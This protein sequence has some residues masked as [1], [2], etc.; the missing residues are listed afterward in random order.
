MVGSGGASPRR[1]RRHSSQGKRRGS[2]RWLPPGD[3]NNDNSTDTPRTTPAGTRMVY[4]QY[5]GHA[6][7][8]RYCARC[9]RP[10]ADNPPRGDVDYEKVEREL[11]KKGDP[12]VGGEVILFEG[13]TWPACLFSPVC[14][15]STYWR[16]T[17]KRI[18]WEHGCCRNHSDTIDMRRVKD[19]A[20]RR[21]VFQRIFGRGTVVVYSDGEASA[22]ILNISMFRAATLYHR[23]R[24]VVAVVVVVV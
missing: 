11:R 17:N 22:P 6:D 19:L 16:I 3:N 12:E 20:L 4:C 14:C 13:T 24:K 23:L 10:Q 18:D 8:G 15:S 9:G 21:N 1:S 7:A 2:G 5:C